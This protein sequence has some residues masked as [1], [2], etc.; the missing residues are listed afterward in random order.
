VKAPDRGEVWLVDLG[1]LG[2]VRPC[3]VLSTALQPQDRA[4]VTIVPHTLSVRGTRFEVAVNPAF[5]RTGAF[6]AQNLITAPSAKFL[7]LLGTLSLA[8]LAVVEDAV[9][10]WLGL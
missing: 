5:L 9:R 6:D 8:Q 2:K 3:L 1:M 10:R 4:L 7:R